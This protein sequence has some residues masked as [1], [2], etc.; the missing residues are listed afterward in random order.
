MKIKHLNLIFK[1]GAGILILIFVSVIRRVED[2]HRKVY[3]IVRRLK[4]TLRCLIR[5]CFF[6]CA[7]SF[8]AKT[9]KKLKAALACDQNMT[10]YI[11]GKYA[12]TNGGTNKAAFFTLRPGT[13]VLAVKCLN[14]HGE[15]GILGSLDN[16]LVTDSRWKCLGRGRKQRLGKKHWTGSLF[17]DTDWPQAVEYF[18]NR[19]WTVWGKMADISDKASWIWTADKGKHEEVYCRRRVSDVTSVKQGQT[20]KGLLNIYVTTRALIIAIMRNAMHKIFNDRNCILLM[21]EIAFQYQY[22]AYFP[23]LLKLRSSP[24]KGIVY[25]LMGGNDKNEK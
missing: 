20:Q 6:S 24:I 12:G 4:S 10:V 21:I 8:S 16:A 5:N 22:I 2:H 7:F 11:D 3:N 15:A 13:H 25:L 19:G 1:K 17:D 23:S 9:T 18:P 14:T